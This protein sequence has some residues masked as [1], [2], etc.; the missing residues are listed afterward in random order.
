MGGSAEGTLGPE[1]YFHIWAV[2]NL[3]K[4]PKR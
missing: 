2:L 3:G 1:D 4:R